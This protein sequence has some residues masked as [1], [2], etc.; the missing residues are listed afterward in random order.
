MSYSY[1]SFTFVMVLNIIS[2]S[3]FNAVVTSGGGNFS[4]DVFTLDQIR[5]NI[6]VK[7]TDFT[8][9]R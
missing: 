7:F 5:G 9:Y 8:S 1:V 2:N 4:E 3:F 6:K